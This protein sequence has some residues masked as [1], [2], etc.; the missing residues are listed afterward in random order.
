[1]KVPPK[2]QKTLLGVMHWH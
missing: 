2:K 1:M